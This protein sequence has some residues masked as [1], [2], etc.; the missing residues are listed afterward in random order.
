MA[1]YLDDTNGEGEIENSCVQ[2]GETTDNPV[3]YGEAICDD[4][5]GPGV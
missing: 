4:C 5:Q 3:M 2:C 1:S